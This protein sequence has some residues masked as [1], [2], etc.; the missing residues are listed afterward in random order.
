VLRR[1]ARRLYLVLALA[2]S[3]SARIERCEGVWRG[4]LEP[5]APPLLVEVELHAVDNRFEGL[6]HIP[7][8]RTLRPLETLEFGRERVAFTFPTADG[9]V[10]FE[11]RRSGD[12]V[13]G[14]FG[15]GERR[16]RLVLRRESALAD[17]LPYDV[18]E[19]PLVSGARAF[20]GQLFLPRESARAP[21]VVLL[22][23]TSMPA[24]D[25]LRFFADLFARRG[26]AA[27]AYD[28]RDTCGEY[29]WRS[30]VDLR[31]LATDGVAAWNA[32]RQQP[33]VDPER[34]GFFGF[35]EGGWVAPI[36]ASEVEH[37]AFV[38]NASGPCVSYAELNRHI[39]AASL[40]RNGFT[41][42]DVA[43][44]VDA[45]DQVDA[46]VRTGERAVETRAVLTRLDARPWLRATNLGSRLPTPEEIGTLLRWRA[47]D[48]DPTPYWRA[49]RC[50]VLAVFGAAD[51]IVPVAESARRIE[52]ALADGG[53]AQGEVRLVPGVNHALQP[54][55]TA[56]DGAVTWVVEHVGS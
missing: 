42:E 15:R 44:L 49:L 13:T 11:G 50:P 32:L 17:D 52:A 9:E 29:G 40:R 20:E 27:L 14:N 37:A 55:T 31:D 4:T 46:Y 35:S 23:G 12:S 19:V 24:R 18:V 3:C 28:K 45:L 8:D 36:A 41:E 53:N 21:A 34:I 26:I 48:L 5:P 30:C 47:L 33:R 56:L 39:N 43:E 16:S 38:V 22:H 7:E 25:D 2:A 1:P 6:I 10:G 54:G 51:E